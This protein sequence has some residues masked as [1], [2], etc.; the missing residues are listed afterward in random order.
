MN[1]SAATAVDYLGEL[2]AVLRS[3]PPEPLEAALDAL[4]EARATGRR[5]YV[6]GNGGSAA[7]ASQFVCNLVKTA[8]VAGY[9]PLRAFALTDNTPSLTAWANDTAY[10]QIFAR[11]IHAL[12]EP[13]DVVIAISSSGNS[14]NIVA[15]LQAAQAIGARTIGLL[16]FDGGR[17]L[18]LVEIAIHV[19]FDNYGLVEDTHMAIGHALTRAL[20]QALQR[21]PARAPVA[22]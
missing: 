18:S 11:Q 19:P 4:L 21:E 5:V 14:P 9:E 13:G 2:G 22:G 8:Q 3:V 7:I 15:G 17:A 16:G 6:M 20:R 12:V 10:D 1:G